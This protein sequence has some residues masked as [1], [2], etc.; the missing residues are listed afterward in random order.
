MNNRKE[1]QKIM[2]G[3]G[4]QRKDASDPDYQGKFV[5]KLSHGSYPTLSKISEAYQ[6]E[7]KARFFKFSFTLFFFSGKA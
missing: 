5:P 2:P 3:Q 1:Q 4:E 7:D 6:V